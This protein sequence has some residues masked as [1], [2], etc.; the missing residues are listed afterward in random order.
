MKKNSKRTAKEER[1][2]MEQLKQEGE[3]TAEEAGVK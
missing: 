3:G 1:S 2:E